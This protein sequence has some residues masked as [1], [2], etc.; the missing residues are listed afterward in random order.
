MLKL[1]FKQRPVDIPADLRLYRRLAMLIVSL[2][3]CC[4]GGTGS[5]KQ[6]HFINS[7]YLDKNFRTLYL[8]FRNKKISLRILSPSADPYLN[9]CINYAIAAD[10]ILQKKIQTGIRFALTDSGKIFLNNLKNDGLIED[11]FRMS[12]FLGKISET[13]IETAL[14]VRK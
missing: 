2:S 1:E 14:N 4:R 5:L 9:R 12:S 6:L 8:E 11:V 10:L 7:F 13:E 3:E